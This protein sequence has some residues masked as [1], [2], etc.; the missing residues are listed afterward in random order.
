MYSHYI[1]I[2]NN[3][4]NIFRLSIL[5][6]TNI[7]ISQHLIS[8]LHSLCIHSHNLNFVHVLCH[9]VSIHSIMKQI[10]HFTSVLPRSHVRKACVT[11]IIPI[12]SWKDTLQ[13]LNHFQSF[14]YLPFLCCIFITPCLWVSIL[15]HV[16]DHF[17]NN[18][19][20]QRYCCIMQVLCNFTINTF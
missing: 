11:K 17:Y 19:W 13:D 7:K 18:N 1:H 14:Y 2:K 20:Q 8:A 3:E 4:L 6:L 12:S 15:K 5:S 16:F 9:L 10:I